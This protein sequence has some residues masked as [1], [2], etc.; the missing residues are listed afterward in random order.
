MDEGSTPGHPAP[1]V[2]A[3]HMV[4]ALYSPLPCAE[5]GLSGR[6]AGR[7]VRSNVEER[8]CKMRGRKRFG[9]GSTLGRALLELLLLCGFFVLLVG[10]VVGI[11]VVNVAMVAASGQIY[12][13]QV[14]ASGAVLLAIFGSALDFWTPPFRSK[15]IS[16][17]EKV[18][19]GL[20]ALARE[21]AEELGT[22][23][24]IE[25]YL[26]RGASAYV[27]QVGGFLGLGSRRVMG[28]GA[29]LLQVLQRD[30]LRSVLAHELGRFLVGHSPVAALVDRA[31][32]YMLAVHAAMERPSSFSAL[33]QAARLVASL[34]VKV[35]LRFYLRV[36]LKG[37]RLQELAA[38]EVA[39]QVAGSV[40]AATAISKVTEAG[41]MVARYD[42]EV[43]AVVK[44]GYHPDQVASGFLAFREGFYSA[45]EREHL[46]RA[47]MS[48]HGGPF[49]AFP[50]LAERLERF[51]ASSVLGKPDARGCADLLHEPDELLEHM[52]MSGR[53]VARSP[54]R[55]RWNQI[56]EYVHVPRHAAAA[57][58]YAYT[59]R[60]LVGRADRPASYRSMLERLLSIVDAGAVM[61]VVDALEP[62]AYPAVRYAMSRTLF[63]EVVVAFALGALYEVGGKLEGGLV[64]PLMMVRGEDRQTLLDLAAESLDHA[65]ARQQLLTFLA[66]DRAPDQPVVPAADAVA[67]APE[68]V[69]A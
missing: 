60:G 1:A 48:A 57:Q 51:R 54:S 27:V 29:A 55:L 3:S 19:P 34:P 16:L 13:M 40:A 30:E 65:A 8:G 33:A 52:W 36:S 50:T 26:E 38:D 37:S 17:H 24:P 68:L 12:L 59:L 39:A 67:V 53:G 35:Y 20:Y 58:R 61:Q 28:V 22:E 42:Q 63:Y 18:A 64:A 47:L 7:W 11:V 10:M 44:A 49:D 66:G 62:T 45:P 46:Q 5:L 32:R 4:G 56:A 9:H 25:I 23:A 15:G 31:R 2:A 41:A 69:Q 6:L 21:V 43:D 14:V